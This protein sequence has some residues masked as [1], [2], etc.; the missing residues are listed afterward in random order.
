MNPY[1]QL[2]KTNSETKKT[3]EFYKNAAQVCEDA[4]KVRNDAWKN[5]QVTITEYL[6]NLVPDAHQLTQDQLNE[7]V[8]W[9][10]VDNDTAFN[11]LS[12]WVSSLDSTLSF[13]GS[14]ANEQPYVELKLRKDQ[15]VYALEQVLLN[16][17]KSFIVAAK[18]QKGSKKTKNGE[19]FFGI[20][21]K[22]CSADGSYTLV[23]NPDDDLAK[24]TLTFYG[25]TTVVFSG[26]VLAALTTVATKYYY[27]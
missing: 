25:S 3:W 19:V 6:Q 10:A 15:D 18:T 14:W 22:T 13:K 27:R 12:T 7:L 5:L 8:S 26:T 21:E 1:A 17:A 2:A 20:F 4:T 24:V 16:L 23:V 9:S 11:I